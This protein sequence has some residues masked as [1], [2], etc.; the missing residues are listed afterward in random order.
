L[1]QIV[2]ALQNYSDTCGELPHGTI[3]QPSLAPD[4]R[5]SWLVS[6]LP[7]L[8]EETL[9]K[10]FD[11]SSG[12]AG[13]NN[14]RSS[15]T[16]V[17]IFICPAQPKREP[18]APWAYSSYVGIAGVGADAASLPLE[19]KRCG[20][21]GYERHVMMQDVKDGVNSTLSILETALE[22][23]HWDAG[24]SATVR[25]IDSEQEPYIGEDR[26]FGIDHRQPSLGS[27]HFARQPLVTN[28]AMLD[29]S[30]R[31]LQ[32]SINPRI[33]EALATIAGNES[34]PADF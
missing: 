10:Q 14:Q 32:A 4:E 24:G 8:E 9:Y 27:F 26:P 1:K 13:K 2:L 30:V 5:L 20:V 29:G 33:L 12:R 17:K 16:P 25:P 23:G 3:A 31:T 21:F 22:N 15:A 7:Y 18:N 28:A 11:P 19:D 6:L 34:I